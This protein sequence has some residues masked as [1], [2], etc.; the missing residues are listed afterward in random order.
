MADK[1]ETTISRPNIFPDCRACI[2]A[3]RMIDAH[4]SFE[5]SIPFVSVR[6]TKINLSC[7]AQGDTVKLLDESEYVIQFLP[8][9]KEIHIPSGNIS[10]QI[11]PCPHFSRHTRSQKATKAV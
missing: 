1:V 10:P 6:T 5:P 9:K 8:N 3:R 2:V 11:V 4:L 7:E